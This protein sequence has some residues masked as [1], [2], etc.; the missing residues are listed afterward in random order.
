MSDFQAK[1]I[2][3]VGA[4]NVATHLG[5]ALKKAGHHIIQVYS[6]TASHANILAEMLHSESVCDFNQICGDADIY[7]FSVK[8]SVLEEAIAAVSGKIGKGKLLLH[9][10]GSMPMSIFQDCADH[11]G[12]MY[13][14]QTF[15]KTRPLD[16]R[17]IPVFLEASDDATAQILHLLATSVSDKVYQLS[18]EDRK[19]LHLSAVWSCNFV[20]HC[21]D[22]AAQ[23]LQEKHIPY[24]VLLP[25]IQE[26]SRKIE[27]LNP[28]DAQTGPAIRY[29]ENV[30]EA[31]LQLMDNH[32]AWQEL[33]RRLSASIHERAME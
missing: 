22:I 26:T 11:Y 15:S 23:I 17:Q 25:L 32:P 5:V 12:V 27:Q 10:A 31:Q 29:D 3:I 21:Y 18:S 2:V 14:M 33:Y 13:P 7:I 8:D 24:H 1:N 20:N 6:R 16:F 28:K 30:M 19:Y 9:T 4:G